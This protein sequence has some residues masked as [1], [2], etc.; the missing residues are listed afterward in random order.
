MESNEVSQDVQL[1]IDIPEDPIVIIGG[2]IVGSALAA[3]LSEICTTRI[4]VIE[5][6]IDELQGS[7]GHA[8]GFVGQ[9]NQLPALTQLAKCSVSEYCKILGG[10]DVVGGLEIASSPDGIAT[11]ERRYQLA[12]DAGLPAEIL[13]SAEAANLAPQWHKADTVSKALYFLSDGTANAKQIVNKYQLAAKSRG[14]T[15]T[16]TKALSIVRENGRISEVNTSIGAIKAESVVIA[17]G[18]WTTQL[19]KPLGIEMPIIPVAHPYVHG[20]QRPPRALSTPFV[21]WPELHVYARDHGSFDG[22]GSYDHH[23]IAVETLRSTAIETWE[24]SF[25]SVVAKALSFFP[26]DMD[27]T[28]MNKFNGVFAVTPDGLPLA[29]KHQ[30]VQGLWVASAIWIT[31]AAGVAKIVADML[32]GKTID[33]SISRVIDPNR[34]IGQDKTELRRMALSTY[35]NIYNKVE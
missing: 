14:T 13:T 2:G 35:S 16:K 11:L 25:D 5:P 17:A 9:L 32:V 10:F 15:F 30:D 4:I 3:Y 22:F 18:I 28:D 29:G 7:T 31:H 1:P 27:M 26:E 34:F 12:R 8:P 23:P 21:R 20:P 6:S 19:L 24:P 33:E